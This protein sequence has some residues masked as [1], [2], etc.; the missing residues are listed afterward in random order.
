MYAC[1]Y[2][3]EEEE[4]EEEIRRRIYSKQKGNE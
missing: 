1:V 4:E 3:W 2:I